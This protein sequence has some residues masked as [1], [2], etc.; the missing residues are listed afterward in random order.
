MGDA[1]R[2]AQVVDGV[3]VNVIEVDPAAVPDWC[4]DWPEAG[5][6][7]P[8]DAWPHAEPVEIAMD[9]AFDEGLTAGD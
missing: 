6:C 8:G 2:L 4:E 1:M 7:G 3:V 9:V 5:N